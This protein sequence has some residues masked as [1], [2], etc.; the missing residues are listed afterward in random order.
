MEARVDV[1]ENDVV[2]V[3][4]GDKASVKSMPTAI[5]GFTGPFTRSRTLENHRRRDSGRS[6]KL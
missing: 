5:A 4:V 2:N 1:N 3:K 6:D